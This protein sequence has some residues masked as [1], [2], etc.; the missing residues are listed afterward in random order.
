MNETDGKH[1]SFIHAKT[2]LH[3]DEWGDKNIWSEKKRAEQE[4]PHS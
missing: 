3:K 1:L 2:C 4:K